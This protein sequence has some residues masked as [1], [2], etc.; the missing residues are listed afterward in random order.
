MKPEDKK[1]L[2]ISIA[3]IVF[4]GLVSFWRIKNFEFPSLEGHKPT[5][6]EDNTPS[7]TDLFSEEK[8]KELMIESGIT[9]EENEKN[10]TYTRKTIDD[11]LVFD[12][13]SSWKIIPEEDTLPFGEK[14]KTLLIIYSQKT[15]SPK[16]ITLFKVE[17]ENID[18][19]SSILE[20][21]FKK[22]DEKINI[23]VEEKDNNILVQIEEISSNN[24]LYLPRTVFSDN[25][26]YLFII[27][28][29]KEDIDSPII[30]YI[31]SSVQII[32]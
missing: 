18:A 9:F 22:Q 13:P 31:L 30:D 8:I 4:L 24:Y 15:L 2:Y 23:S 26:Y 20:E 21:G 19:F 1:T 29:L 16:T 10:I 12:Y 14:I 25:N 27:N 32:S 11:N 7:F 3:M 28:C 5:K 17:A 6:E